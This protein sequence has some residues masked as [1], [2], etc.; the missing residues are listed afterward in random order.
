MNLQNAIRNRQMAGAIIDP[1]DLVEF[2]QPKYDGY[3]RI[4]QFD[5][6]PE[7]AVCTDVDYND[8]VQ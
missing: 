7:S 8:Q 2:F 6:I 3:I 4:P 1:L 5:G